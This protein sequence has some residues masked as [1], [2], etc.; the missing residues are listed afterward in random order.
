METIASEHIWL[1]NGKFINMTMFQFQWF[2]KKWPLSCR[3]DSFFLS[4]NSILCNNRWLQSWDMIFLLNARWWC[5]E[6]DEM[7]PYEFYWL[8]M[9]IEFFYIILTT[10]SSPRAYNLVNKLN[11]SE[12]VAWTI[13][14]IESIH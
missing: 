14:K 5:G 6:V 10:L 2:I 9:E 3:Y 8:E 7:H 4:K 11:D 1:H 12:N 13:H